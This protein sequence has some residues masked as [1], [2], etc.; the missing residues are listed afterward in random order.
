MGDNAQLSPFEIIYAEDGVFPIEL[1]MV[2][3]GWIARKSRATARLDA[4]GKSR[5]RAR[6]STNGWIWISV[7]E[8]GKWPTACIKSRPRVLWL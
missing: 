8:V 3:V 1:V 7:G 5:S 2:A 4:L 6:S